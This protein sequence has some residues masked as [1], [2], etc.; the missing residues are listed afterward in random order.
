MNSAKSASSVNGKLVDKV[1]LWE[2]DRATAPL[3]AQD[4]SGRQK[5]RRNWL[6]QTFRSARLAITPKTAHL[7]TP[8][9][10]VPVWASPVRS[11]F[12]TA[13]QLWVRK[14]SPRLWRAFPSLVSA[15]EEKGEWEEGTCNPWPAPWAKLWRSFGAEFLGEPLGCDA[16]SVPQLEKT[17]L[18]PRINFFA[19]SVLPTPTLTT[20]HEKNLT[21][22]LAP[23]GARVSRE[24]GRVRG[25][26]RQSPDDPLAS[27][28]SESRL[29]PGILRNPRSG[30][31]RRQ[32]CGCPSLRP[33]PDFPNRG[34]WRLSTPNRRQPSRQSGPSR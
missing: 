29:H 15:G 20:E 27:L 12:F 33:H 34:R 21:T 24:A 6:A 26:T 23:L 19:I 18:R 32:S 1:P 22:A 28:I 8:P 16:S 14:R 5:V 2:P 4:L 25:F 17:V 10:Q 3:G 13:S 30:N 11:D 31:P 9:G 7:P